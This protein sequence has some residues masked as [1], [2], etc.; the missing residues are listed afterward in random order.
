MKKI[1]FTLCLFA[2]LLVSCSH[3]KKPDSGQN[4]PPPAHP[5]LKGTKWKTSS[6]Q[7][8]EFSN[9]VGLATLTSTGYPFGVAL[10][11]SYEVEDE[12]K[13]IIKLDD[14]I[15]KLENFGEKELAIVFKE[16]AIAA[17]IISYEFML[18]DE[19]N[20]LS[21][22]E[23]KKLQDNITKLKNAKD[24]ITDKASLKKFLIEIFYPMNIEEIEE[25]LK[26]SG[27]PDDAKAKMEAEL[28]NMKDAIADPSKVD[29]LLDQGMKEFKEL[30]SNEL[31][32]IKKSNPIT[33]KCEDGETIKT[34]EKLISSNDFNVSKLE[35]MYPVKFEEGDEFIKKK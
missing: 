29:A 33:L 25:N 35:F 28:K 17:T 1:M 3:K 12:K 26:L 21:D 34:T 31:P 16:T 18:N 5:A 11:A 30:I 10:K 9:D 8:I 24:S 2:I 23:K 20:Q 7:L 19:Q 32:G 4:S 6:D 13:V 14:F 15:S 22:A 27:L